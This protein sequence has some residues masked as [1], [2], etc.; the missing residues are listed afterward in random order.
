MPITVGQLRAARGLIGWSQ[1]ELAKAAG[2]GRATIADFE[3]GKRDPYDRTIDLI[4]GALERAGVEFTNGERPGVR[5]RP[6]FALEGLEDIAAHLGVTP[7]EAER[8]CVSGELRAF[9]VTASGRWGVTREAL[10][11][12]IGARR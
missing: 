2:V 7:G 12:F 10:N 5:M 11:E 4:Q 1:L 6:S 8:L 9:R 3:T